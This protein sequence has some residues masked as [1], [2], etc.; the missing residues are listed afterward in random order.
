LARAL[1][2]GA[3]VVGARRA[4]EVVA[5]ISEDVRA[6]DGDLVAALRSLRR[7]GP[8][9]ARWSALARQLRDALPPAARSAAGEAGLPDDLA[10]GLVVALAHPDRIARARTGSAAYLMASGT[11]ALLPA[12]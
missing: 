2:D 6:R 7:G 9:S 8:E 10:V 5:M 11:G 1:L 12:C 3:A 4:A